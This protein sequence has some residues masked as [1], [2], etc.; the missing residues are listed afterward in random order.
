M[1]NNNLLTSNTNNKNNEYDNENNNENNLTESDY[2]SLCHYCFNILIAKIEK[3]Q[4][5]LI[6]PQ[7]FINVK[8]KNL[9]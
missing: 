7:K 4:T 6:F 5:T 9:L 8:K 3:K 2:K 1:N